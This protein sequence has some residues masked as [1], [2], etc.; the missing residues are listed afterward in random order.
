[1][2]HKCYLE[3][4]KTEGLAAVFGLTLAQCWKEHFIIAQEVLSEKITMKPTENQWQVEEKEK[5][6][7]SEV[8]WN[9]A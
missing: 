2:L 4:P 5:C 1:M 9:D 7:S 8:S 3:S 6:P